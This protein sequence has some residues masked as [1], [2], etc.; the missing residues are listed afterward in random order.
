MESTRGNEKKR[1]RFDRRTL[2]PIKKQTAPARD[3]VKFIARMRLL[4]VFVFGCVKFD[5]NR[6]VVKN[7]HRKIPGG[8]G[9]AVDA[10][11]KL[12]FTR[13]GRI[14]RWTGTWLSSNVL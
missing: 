7:R 11:F 1:T 4:P 12:T 2:P 14:Q 3:E 6:S 13:S 10:F 8:G 9:P 5:R